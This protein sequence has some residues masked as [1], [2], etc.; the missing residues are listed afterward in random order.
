[1]FSIVF[2]ANPSKLN[3]SCHCSLLYRALPL[4]R[5]ARDSAVRSLMQAKHCQTY[6]NAYRIAQKTILCPKKRKVCKVLIPVPGCFELVSLIP[7]VSY[8]TLDIYWLITPPQ[9]S[10]NITSETMCSYRCGFLVD[11]CNDNAIQKRFTRA[12]TNDRI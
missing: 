2:D 5:C 10:L 1:M 3:S 9:E 6:K 11:T 7:C 8:T 12:E 4:G